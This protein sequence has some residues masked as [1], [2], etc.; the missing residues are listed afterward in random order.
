MNGHDPIEISHVIQLAGFFISV[1]VMIINTL[2]VLYLKRHE[3]KLNFIESKIDTKVGKTDFECICEE[4]RQACRPSVCSEISKIER[5][6]RTDIEDMWG[7]F[8]NHTHEGLSKDSEI[9]IK[10]SK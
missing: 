4:R 8:K 10:R 9:I 3:S 5:G 2:I 7:E 6:H 1:V